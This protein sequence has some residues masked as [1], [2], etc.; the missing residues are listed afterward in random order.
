M[1]TTRAT[2]SPRNAGQTVTVQQVSPMPVKDMDWGPITVS[3]NWGRLFISWKDQEIIAVMQHYP[4][5]IEALQHFVEP[6]TPAAE[7]QGYADA[8]AA[9]AALPYNGNEAGHED[10]YRAVEALA[11]PPDTHSAGYVEGLEAAAKYHDE[12][13]AKLQ[14]IADKYPQT[15][16]P[17]YRYRVENHQTAARVIRAL[18]ARK[19]N[20]WPQEEISPGVFVAV[21]PESIARAALAARPAEQPAADTRL[22]TPQE[23]AQILYDTMTTNRPIFDAMVEAAEDIEL[24]GVSFNRVVGDALRAAIAWDAPAIIGTATP[25]PSDKIADTPSPAL[26]VL[27]MRTAAETDSFDQLIAE[28][29]AEADRAMIKFPQPNYVISK[30][31]EEAGE[32]VK[33]AIHCAEGRETPENVIGEM[34]QTIAMLYRLW[35][36][37]DQVH[38]LA[39]L[40][41]FARKG[42]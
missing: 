25:A 38:G 33:A 8:L 28:A 7:P 6:A 24:T 12:Q 30:V 40:A 37:G 17:E 29:K 2:R 10:A 11:L 4:A 22:V 3:E 36:E 14:E 34:R 23:A 15:R 16:I 1:T 21:D 41:P 13:A 20:T 19:P 31:A 26:A 9:I 39:A 32:V 5:L 18:A 27:A 35:V 42:E